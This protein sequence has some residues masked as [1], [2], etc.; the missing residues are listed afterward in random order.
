MSGPPMSGPPMSGPPMS[1][2]PASA[3]P[4]SVPSHDMPSA[5]SRYGSASLFGG[6][7]PQHRSTEPATYRS[8]SANSVDDGE[9]RQPTIPRQQPRHGGFCPACGA[10]HGAHDAFCSSC[11]TRL[12]T[13]AAGPR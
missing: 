12:E 9:P 6:T 13:P 1:G 7:P 4:M 2:P 8:E 5:G 11:G 3:P 10:S